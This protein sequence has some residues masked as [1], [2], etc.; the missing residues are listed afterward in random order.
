MG[1]ARAADRAVAGSN[2]VEEKRE[3]S[4]AF[5]GSWVRVNQADGAP[6]LELKANARE[7]KN[8]GGRDTIGTVCGDECGARA[9]GK[10]TQLLGA[11]LLYTSPS[12]RDGL[13][14]RMPSSA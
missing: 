5:P 3:S 10:L 14:S 12:P 2:P 1:A 6:P 11:C 9:L 13:L 4:C 8:F 7:K